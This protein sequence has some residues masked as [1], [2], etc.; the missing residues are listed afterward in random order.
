MEIL[1]VT[2]V[3]WKHSKNISGNI[4]KVI[5]LFQY[6]SEHEAEEYTKR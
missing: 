4:F 2:E 3:L 5:N 6:L 1:V